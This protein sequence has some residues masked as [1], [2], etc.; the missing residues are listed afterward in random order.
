MRGVRPTACMGPMVVNYNSLENELLTWKGAIVN[1]IRAGFKYL[2]WGPLI[3][4]CPSVFLHLVRG[5]RFSGVDVLA[6]TILLPLITGLT[7]AL[8]WKIQKMLRDRLTFALLAVLGIWLLGPAMMMVGASYSGGGFSRPD[9][10]HTVLLATA[11][12]PA[13][14]F[15]MST[16]DGTLGALLLTSALLP[17]VSALFRPTKQA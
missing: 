5:N 4:W 2:I 12:F 3:F 6:L 8:R 11:M 10:I 17:L 9:S 1:S 7:L 14:T 13:F 15:V 16:Y